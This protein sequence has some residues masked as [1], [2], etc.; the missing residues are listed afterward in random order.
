M[1]SPERQ[2]TRA[3][4]VL[5]YQLSRSVKSTEQLRKIMIQREIDPEI[6]EPILIRFTEAGLIDD[7]QFAEVIV[8]ARRSYKGLAKSSIKREL[9][10]KGVEQGLIESA[11]ADITNEDELELAKELAI[12]RF[13][14][15]AHLDFEV[16]RRRLSGYLAR[17]G[18]SGAVVGA[19]CRFA[20]DSFSPVD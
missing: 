12:K 17:K 4:N 7:K 3:R 10:E 8:R 9:V 16:R 6:F 5:L 1:L 2:E 11:L 15:M 18:Y 14:R 19:A 13:A 20:E